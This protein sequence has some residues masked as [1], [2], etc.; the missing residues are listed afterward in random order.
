[1]EALS[2]ADLRHASLRE[3]CSSSSW[4]GPSETIQAV[5]VQK[6]CVPPLLAP[7]PQ[8]LWSRGMRGRQTALQNRTTAVRLNLHSRARLSIVCYFVRGSAAQSVVFA[9]AAAT[10]F[11]TTLLGAVGGPVTPSPRASCDWDVES[12]DIQV[13]H[14]P[15][16]AL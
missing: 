2:E 16:P 10:F 6:R 15:L 3:R 12:T 1:M 13:P 7:L 9:A 14:F 8:H 11:A 4:R 5:T